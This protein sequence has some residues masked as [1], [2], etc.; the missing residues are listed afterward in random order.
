MTPD[1]RMAL[2][3]QWPYVGRLSVDRPQPLRDCG[4]RS[5]HQGP[6][7]G[8]RKGAPNGSVSR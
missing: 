2:P 4:T 5:R 3:S 6:A 8:G 1:G 7:A